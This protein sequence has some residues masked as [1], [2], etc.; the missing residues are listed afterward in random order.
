MVSRQGHAH[1]WK[2]AP[3][4]FT[5][6]ADEEFA[7]LGSAARSETLSG[8][9]PAPAHAAEMHGHLSRALADVSTGGPTAMVQPQL[10]T[11]RTAGGAVFPAASGPGVPSGDAPGGFAA[12]GMTPRAAVQASGRV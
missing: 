2:H 5:G 3:A 10:L 4:G 9:F 8:L 7:P 6:G 11:A 1:V 12:A